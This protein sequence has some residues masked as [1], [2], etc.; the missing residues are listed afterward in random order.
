MTADLDALF[1]QTKSLAGRPRTVAGLPGGLT[2]RNYQVT[3]P[4]G[5]YDDLAPQLAAGPWSGSAAPPAA[6]PPLI[7]ASSSRMSS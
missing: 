3:T 5:I 2:N 7:S 1:A 4:A 6:S